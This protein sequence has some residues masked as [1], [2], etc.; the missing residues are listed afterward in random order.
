MSRLASSRSAGGSF[1]RWPR[2]PGSSAAARR[3]EDSIARVAEFDC[4]VLLTGETGSGKEEIARAIHAA[5]PRATK[6]F[7]SV[8]CGGLVA[9]LA[10]SQLFGHEKGAFT[11]A[12]G[13]TFGVFRAADGGVVFLDEIGEMPIDLQ[14]KLLQVLQRLEVMP[15][16]STRG[17]HVDVMVIAA[18]NRDLDAAVAE[19][20]FRE[21]LFYRLN[22]VC[23]TV[24]PLRERKDD[25]PRFIGLFSA[26]FAGRYGRPRWWPSPDVLARLVEH[27]WPG[28]VRQL[29]QFV[30]RIYVFE[31]RADEV[32]QELFA[33]AG[34]AGLP[35]EIPHGGALPSAATEP[36]FA[37]GPR[38]MTAVA[39]EPPLPVFNL[40]ELRRMA[41][42][43][44]LAATGG[45]R[46]RAASML[47]V[48]LNTMTRLVAEACPELAAAVKS[49]RKRSVKPK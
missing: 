3:L 28:N 11:G 22:T 14:P 7:I 39:N 47:G 41:V 40:E 1:A 12:D 43:Q 32:L 27:P 8:N 17:H 25:I 30:Q 35:T 21:D 33:E 37:A 18:T 16:G 20:A 5:G 38:S 42:R 23:L 31:D 46:G 29:A 15:V 44:C 34:D 45:H 6:P 49:G 2:L 36:G 19:G 24:P 13:P 4:P 10:E 26:H 48:S 9:T